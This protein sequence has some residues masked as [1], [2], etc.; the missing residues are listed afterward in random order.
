MFFSKT[1]PRETIS[2]AV[3]KRE[4]PTYTIK[5]DKN[6]HKT[7]H[8]TGMT[9]FYNLIQEHAEE[10]KIEN[11]LKRASMGD[12]TALNKK[13]PAWFDATTMPTTMGERTTRMRTMRMQTTLTQTTL[14]RMPTPMLM[15]TTHL[16]MS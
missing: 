2:L 4:K 11:I 14:Q 5:V 15:A 3:G 7:V 13:V 10:C 6:G 1:K 16:Q 12:T 9:N 8:K